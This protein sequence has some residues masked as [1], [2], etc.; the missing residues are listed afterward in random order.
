[1]ELLFMLGDVGPGFFSGFTMKPMNQEYAVTG[2]EH[3]RKRRQTM[4]WMLHEAISRYGD[5]PAQAYRPEVKAAYQY[6]TFQDFYGIVRSIALSLVELGVRPADRIALIAD[7]G[8]EF[9][10]CC[11]GVNCM[12][13]VD[14]PRGTDAT[15][16]DL[17][18]IFAHSECR[19]AILQDESVLRKLSPFMDEFP[20]LE[21]I[22]IIKPYNS[23][24]AFSDSIPVSSF[25]SL[26]KYAKNC[27]PEKADLFRFV[28]ENIEESDPLTIIY[29]SG[30]TGRPKGVLHIHSSF[31][32]E[33]ENLNALFSAYIPL[34]G[35]TLGYL[36][37]WHIAERLM[38]L[39]ALRTGTA[40]AFTSVASLQRDL[41]EL[42]PTFLLSVPR[43]W[44][45]FY[46]RIQDQVKRSSS[47]KRALFYAAQ[48]IALRYSLLRDA[49]TG[50][51]FHLR[52]KGK[53][54]W[55]REKTASLVA[56]LP[57]FILNIPA[58]LVL[59]KVRDLFGGRVRF[60]FSGAGALPEHIDRFFYSVG[61]PIVE[62]YGMTETVGVSAV[63][64]LPH[65][66]VGVVGSPLPGVSVEL[67]DEHGRVVSE[68]G[69]KGVA[70]HSGPHI[71]QGYYREP[72]KTAEVLQNGWLNSGDILVWTTD[73]DLKFTGR[74]KDTI[75]LSGGENVEPHPIEGALSQSPLIRFVVVV[76][77]D[78]K[79]LGALIVPEEKA[80]RFAA[81]QSALTLPADMTDWPTD[82]VVYR[83]F[84]NEIARIMGPDSGFKQFERVVDFQIL[85]KDFTIGEEVT[86]SMKLRR[87]VVLEK[88]AI[89][90]EAIFR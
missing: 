70:W 13:A 65:T 82:P 77:Q 57:L 76:G 61:I 90:I 89:E 15:V 10:W 43:V 71:M 84:K 44:E 73:G 28:G 72:E 41:A 54:H 63:R 22:F 60:A 34:G 21:R 87:H 3:D 32:W 49:L 5:L 36:P 2:R 24:E 6:L 9:M 50:R 48:W 16:D 35:I 52:S 75:V 69:V 56:F 4:Y 74:A 40:M 38:E 51:R 12:G 55:L 78:Q 83:M 20:S 14:V 25:T 17:R 62:T 68:P 37:P 31:F 42:R 88:Y 26:L 59:K 39:F 86:G 53:V 7:V 66:V 58:Q 27:P 85:P 18:Y 8:Q 19:F 1:M 30:A 47:L 29:T 46:N 80:V 45:S 64:R 33:V 23:T 11:L 79:A 81:E 67:R